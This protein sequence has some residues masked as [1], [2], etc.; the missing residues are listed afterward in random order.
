[1]KLK[2][3]TAPDLQ[4]STFTPTMDET[5]DFA[6]GELTLFAEVRVYGDVVTTHSGDY[7]TPPDHEIKVDGIEV[8]GIWATDADGEEACLNPIQRDDIE[9]MIIE[10]IKNELT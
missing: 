9:F 7:L 3:K 2:F 10:L 5:L 6:Y 1:M 8:L 4:W